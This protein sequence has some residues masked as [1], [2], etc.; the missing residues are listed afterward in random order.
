MSTTAWNTY[1]LDEIALIQGGGTPKRSEAAF[2][3]GNITWVTPTD[4]PAIGIVRKLNG[5]KETITDLGLSKSSAKL[6][7]PGS[8]LFSSRATIGKIAITNEP[9]ATNQGFANFTPYQD[10]IDLWFLA[11]LLCRFTP[12]IK[13][14]AGKTT[15]LE[16]PR[17]KLKGFSAKV[18]PLLD[19]HN[20]VARIK[21]C[22]D[23]VDEIERLRA[24]VVEEANYL[25]PSLYAAIEDGNKWDK[26]KIG[27]LIIKSRNGRSIRQDSQNATGHVLSLRAVHDV[28]LDLSERKPIVLPAPIAAQYAIA[29]GDVF[30]SRSNTKELV[31]LASVAAEKTDR[32]IYPD[33]LIKLEPCQDIVR[34]RFLAY[35]LRTPASRRQIKDRAV[36]TSQSMVKISGQRLKDVEVP[37][38]P[39]YV[40]DELIERF[41]ELHDLSSNLM[42]D[43]RSLNSSKL[44]QSIL[45]KAFAGEL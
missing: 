29:I 37:V 30:V 16:I 25:A 33:L 45:R 43:L 38:P 44:R 35:A 1:R 3:G 10:K 27:N 28:T 21:E 20:I 26:M 36:G 2:F 24:E 6:I 14:L 23:R 39:L 13:A 17:G 4:L 9:C 41:D 11:F 42:S 8:V 12:E 40:Q 7:R 15:F 34:S 32:V 18:P 22:M 31:G 5:T 19:Q